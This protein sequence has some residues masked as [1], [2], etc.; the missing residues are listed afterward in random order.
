MPPQS[1]HV[2]L[3][4]GTFA[5]GAPWT[6]SGSR[7]ASALHAGL[8]GPVEVD[9][10]DWSGGNSASAREDG[11]RRLAAHL[12]EAALRHPDA[13]RFVVAHSHGG[14]VALYAMRDGEVARLTQGVVCLSTPFLV[15]RPRDLGPQ[16]RA[17]LIAALLIAL[18]VTNALFIED[19]LAAALPWL[20]HPVAGLLCVWIGMVGLFFLYRSWDALATRLLARLTL[21]TLPP[22]RL[23]ILR[24]TGDEASALL[25][26]FQFLSL[27]AVRLFHSMQRLHAAVTQRFE[28]WSAN[29]LRMLL[30]AAVGAVITF[31][32]IFATVYWGAAHATLLSVA[33]MAILLFGM[34]TPILLLLGWIST[35][36]IVFRL[37]AT[38]ALLP[39]ALVLAVC[40]LPIDWRVALANLLI[41]VTVEVTPE[42]RWEVHQFVPQSSAVEGTGAPGL[43]HSA[44]YDDERALATIVQWIRDRPAAT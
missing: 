10:C 14:N 28:A 9:H 37:A 36:T 44:I 1:Y 13:K 8:D 19:R 34:V 22:L 12:R 5:R 16:G 40:M 11:A 42:G 39:A 38:L 35:A 21:P 24:A 26:F 32:A 25:L 30:A 20:P 17:N 27:L 41:D 4:H 3:V 33:L 2:T 31:G 43:A 7:L 15:A 29:K 23:S 6:R 18:L